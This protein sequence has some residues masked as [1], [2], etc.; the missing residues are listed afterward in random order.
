MKDFLDD[1]YNNIDAAVSIDGGNIGDITFEAT[2][3]KTYEVNFYGIG[4]H[5]YGAF[6]KMA[7]P[8]SRGGKGSGE[9]S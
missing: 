8:V 6:G 2:G 9:N 5:A 3:F 1:N 7:N 4:G